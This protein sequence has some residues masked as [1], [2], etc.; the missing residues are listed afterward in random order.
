MP[1]THVCMWENGKGYRPVTVEE[2]LRKYP[3]GVSASRGIFVCNLC[4]QNVTFATG[5]VNTAH[6]RH[7]SADEKKECEE[8]QQFVSR[9]IYSMSTHHMPLKLIVNGSTFHLALGFFL[10][11]NQYSQSELHELI[12]IKEPESDTVIRKYSLERMEDGVTT[13][14]DVGQTPYPAYSIK[15]E[16]VSGK[17]WP[18]TT[19]GVNPNGALFDGKTGKMINA[20]AKAYVGRTYYLLHKGIMIYTTMVGVEQIIYQNGWYLYRIRTDEL[21]QT[22][23]RL[24]LKFSVFLTDEPVEF[25]PIWPPYVKDSYF[26]YHN[27]FNLNF[28]LKGDNV[29]IKMFPELNDHSLRFYKTEHGKIYEILSY[30]YYKEQLVALGQY[31]AMGFS[32]LSKGRLERKADLPTVIVEDMS[33]AKLENSSYQS[34]PPMNC[35]LVQGAYDGKVV[36]LEN[37]VVHRIEQ[38]D[39]D[40]KTSIDVSYG[41]EIRIYQGCDL[42]RTI[43]FVKAAQSQNNKAQGDEELEKRLKACRGPTII[44]SHSLG[45]ILEKLKAYPKTKRWIYEQVRNGKMSRKAYLVLLSYVKKMGGK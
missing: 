45:A 21:T 26:I 43:C 41:M 39:I 18:V 37:G 12:V 36:V 31:G 29:E 27:S 20:G 9:S 22:M 32:Y 7:N 10:P 5:E 19:T 6:F 13:Y 25:Y 23:A 44:I 1:L 14:V 8:R 17:Y 15:C 34:L 40:M 33:G 30:D 3:Y 38:L 2:A 11:R 24:F 4:A 42:V 35:I 16:G 28:Y